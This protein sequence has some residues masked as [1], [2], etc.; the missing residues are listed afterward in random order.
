[1]ADGSD[2]GDS[3]TN[4]PVENK[5]R[6]AKGASGNPSGRPPSARNQLAHHKLKLELAVRDGMSK[7]KLAKIISKMADMAIAG[8]T[9]AARLIL[10]KF[11]SSAV[12][13]DAEVEQKDNS[14]KILITNAT[15]K[16]QADSANPPIDVQVQEI[17]EKH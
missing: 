9:K 10:D 17:K 6:F 4:L 7:D 3:V 13:P 14:I 2:A 8:D 12:A 15:Y 1:M 11:I 5:G 16:A